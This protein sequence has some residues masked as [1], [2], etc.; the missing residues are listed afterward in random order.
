M[1]V[2]MYVYIYIYMYSVYQNAV[3]K[4]S[5]QVNRKC[6]MV[7]RMC[8]PTRMRSASYRSK[9]RMCMIHRKRSDI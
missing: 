7:Y 8:S 1:Y 6:S 3:S 4:L 9:L 5:V 2:C